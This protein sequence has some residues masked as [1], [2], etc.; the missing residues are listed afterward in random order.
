M[1]T[2]FLTVLLMVGSL[3][4]ADD[5][6]STRRI[7]L[8]SIY[9]NPLPG[10]LL[11]SLD[12]NLQRVSDE[13]GWI[14]LPAPS[15]GLK[16]EHVEVLH[17]LFH[18]LVGIVHWEDSS[19]TI[20][21]LI[22]KEHIKEELT[23]TARTTSWVEK[24]VA[25]PVAESVVTQVEIREKLSD[26]IVS[27]L[28]HTPGV[29]TVGKGGYAVAPSIRGLARRRIL[30]LLDGVRMVS[31]RAAGSSLSFVSPDL[32][33]RIEVVRSGAS[34]AYGSDA[35]GGVLHAMTPAFSDL[36]F[37]RALSLTGSLQSERYALSGSW[38]LDLGPF[39][40][41]AFVGYAQAGD[42]GTPTEKILH[43]GYR[44]SSVQLNLVSNREKRSYSLT[45]IGG[46]GRNIGKPERSNDMNNYSVSPVDDAQILTF[47]WHEKQ[48][49]QNGDLSAQV[50]Y[51]P[52]R[53]RVDKH[54]VSTRQLE[55]ATTTADNFGL[56]VLFN[57]PLFST[58]SFSTGIDGF[59]RRN[60]QTDSVV[61]VGDQLVRSL[62]MTHGNRRDLAA[63]LSLTFNPVSRLEIG[64]GIRHTIFS[65]EADVPLGHM[66][67]DSAAFSGFA[68][69]RYQF[70]KGLSAFVNLGRSYRAPALTEL[71]YDG[72]SGR[73]RIEG[74]PL[75]RPESSLNLDLGLKLYNEGLYLGLYGFYCRVADLIERYVKNSEV[76]TYDNIASGQI[77]GAEI[78]IQF[79]PSRSLELSG[80]YY[81][82]IGR[83]HKTDAP[84]NDVPTP[85]FLLSGKW[86]LGQAWAELNAIKS[87][88]NPKPGPAETA[89]DSFLTL[90]LK[91]G[92]LVSPRLMMLFK[93]SNLF[94]ASYYPNLDPDITRAPRRDLSLGLQFFLD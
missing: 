19:K 86:V 43:S 27:A 29:Q 82:Y 18:R 91:G 14:D 63:F 66:T 90:D 39:V 75:L 23:V 16:R 59:L 52:T 8:I 3:L 74:N 61:S 22:P 1:K 6:A 55:S 30:L 79:F 81:H 10:V 92:W 84:L 9:R 83:D 31:D 57:K 77:S 94:N 2:C 64:A 12:R 56:R 67:R 49:W 11:R 73:R 72:I 44:N 38:G 58:L 85:Q 46:F 15:A 78:E 20:F 4:A 50:F 24:S 45:Y 71:F 68:T 47:R 13:Q 88:A 33:R 40:F 80:H 42:Y 69:L 17:T 51:H 93:V 21:I 26:N 60:V 89:N 7:E 41:N 35:M 25:M 34:V 32:I 76:Y 36:H 5:S 48:L 87:L 28:V 37:P 54:K 53:Y 62:P 65:L 70:S